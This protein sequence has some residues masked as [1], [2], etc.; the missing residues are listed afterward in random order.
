[1][2]GAS[3][4][5]YVLYVEELVRQVADET[6]ERKLYSFLRETSH[7]YLQHEDDMA[8]LK[9]AM[10]FPPAPLVD[11]LR[12]RFLHSEEQTTRVL[13]SIFE[14]GLTN[15]LL[16]PA[17]VQDLLAACYCLNDGLFLQLFNFSYEHFE[18]KFESSWR[19]FWMGISK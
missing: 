19:I 5:S 14:E 7:Y 8:L 15:G 13:T 17:R 18:E 3:L 12:E 11:R 9:R 1:V 6:V 4:Q 10:L 16:R 2:F